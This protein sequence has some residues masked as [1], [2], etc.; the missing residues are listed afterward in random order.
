MKLS[1]Q[2][3]RCGGVVAGDAHDKNYAELYKASDLCRDN[4]AE[5]QRLIQSPSAQLEPSSAAENV[6]GSATITPVAPVAYTPLHLK[7]SYVLKR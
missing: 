6:A 3:F 4:A 2:L 5:V 7:F 1:P